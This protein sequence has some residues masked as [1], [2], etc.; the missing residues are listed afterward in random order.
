M[1]EGDYINNNQ[2]HFVADRGFSVRKHA[3]EVCNYE[4]RTVNEEGQPTFVYKGAATKRNYLSRLQ[5][6]DFNSTIS[7]PFADRL[8][9]YLFGNVITPEDEVVKNVERLQKDWYKDLVNTF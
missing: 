4:S 3:V 2:L 8:I 5:L 7:Y 1:L 6:L 9:E